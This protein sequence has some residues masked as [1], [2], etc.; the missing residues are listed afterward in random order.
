LAKKWSDYLKLYLKK[1]WFAVP[2]IGL[3]LAPFLYFFR[4]FGVTDFFIAT[5]LAF[6]ASDILM[7]I[8]VRGGNGIFQS[9]LFGTKA[10]P[11]GYGF[12]TFFVALMFVAVVVNWL[13]EQMLTYL[14]TSYGDVMVCIV[15]GLTLSSLVYLI[16]HVRF[17]VRQER[18]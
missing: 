13:T 10:Q 15:I 2:F 7:W 8:F 14:S 6:I 9:R 3:G 18:D 4:G 12:I 16:V 5:I 17:Y 1:P 11:K